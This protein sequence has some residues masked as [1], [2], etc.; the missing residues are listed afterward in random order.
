MAGNSPVISHGSAKSISGIPQLE[1]RVR[2]AKFPDDF[3]AIVEVSR[4]AFIHDPCFMFFGQVV[5]VR[6]V[7]K[8]NYLQAVNPAGSCTFLPCLVFM[9]DAH[10]SLHR[11]HQRV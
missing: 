9:L 11:S 6:P 3:E 5:E 10:P 2:E 8:S 7:P 4:K 1:P